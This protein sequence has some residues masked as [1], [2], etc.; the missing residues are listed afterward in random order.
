MSS[1]VCWFGVYS[2]RISATF[3]YFWGWAG[4]HRHGASSPWKAGWISCQLLY[5]AA[6]RRM[7]QRTREKSRVR[8]QT[9]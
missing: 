3:C 6:G 7:K 9:S 4:C 5:T 2:N 1:A 8:R